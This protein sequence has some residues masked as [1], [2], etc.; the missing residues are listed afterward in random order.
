MNGLFTITIIE[1]SETNGAI[2]N[3]GFV[4]SQPNPLQGLF[5]IPP[6]DWQNLRQDA[7][8]DPLLITSFILEIGLKEFVYQSES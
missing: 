8:K 6:E 5:K 1:E 2:F 4:T 7:L 3:L